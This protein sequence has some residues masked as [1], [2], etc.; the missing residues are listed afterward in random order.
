MYAYVENAGPEQ[1]QDRTT[2]A[3]EKVLFTALLEAGNGTLQ[4]LQMLRHPINTDAVAKMQKIQQPQHSID[5]SH[6]L[7]RSNAYLTTPS[8]HPLRHILRP[9]SKA[10]AYKY[11]P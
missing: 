4:T 5:P 6:H 7:R 11:N 10:Q 8:P 9:P 2:N 1:T 3:T